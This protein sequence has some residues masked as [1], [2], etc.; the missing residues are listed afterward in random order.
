MAWH[1]V[2]RRK[3]SRRNSWREGRRGLKDPAVGPSE[4]WESLIV[5]LM[6]GDHLAN[7]SA[8]LIKPPKEIRGTGGG[9]HLT[10][11][12]RC[13]LP[14]LSALNPF[15]FS[16]FLKSPVMQQNT[17]V[18]IYFPNLVYQNVFSTLSLSTFYAQI[19][20][21]FITYV[22]YS[23]LCLYRHIELKGAKENTKTFQSFNVA[24]CRW[25]LYTSVY[26]LLL[27]L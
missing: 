24:Q 26:W 20:L 9:E 22:A 23:S 19:P 13:Q 14:T 5:F 4:P 25:R 2:Q 18:L 27:C 8:W 1:W 10:T 3:K 12:E 11:G 15:S 6:Y 7:T 21:H 16:F 17:L